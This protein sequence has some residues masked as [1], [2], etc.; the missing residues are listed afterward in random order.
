MVP[1]EFAAGSSKATWATSSQKPNFT[2]AARAQ[3]VVL[4]AVE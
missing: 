3:A 4:Q 2:L 1:D